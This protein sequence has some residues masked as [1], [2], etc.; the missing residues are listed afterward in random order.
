MKTIEPYI[1]AVKKRLK[2]KTY[3]ETMEAIGMKKQAWT[4]IKNGTGVN[5]KNAIRIGQILKI[6]PIEIMAY[7]LAL[8]A[9]NNEIRSMW[10]KLA[11]DKENQRVKENEKQ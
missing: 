6:D 11:K 2:T 9:K 5:E 1:E 8:K 7:S 3:S 4:A 10:L